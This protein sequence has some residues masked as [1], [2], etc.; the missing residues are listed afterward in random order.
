MNLVNN[1]KRGKNVPTRRLAAC[2]FLAGLMAASSVALTLAAPANAYDGHGGGGGHSGHFAGRAGGGHFAITAHFGG[3]G[4]GGGRFGGSSFRGGAY[5]GGRGSGGWGRG[6]WKAGYWGPGWYGYWPLALGFGYYYDAALA[7]PYVGL[8]AWDIGYG[9]G[10]TEADVRAQQN[11]MVQATSVPLDQPIDWNSANGDVSGSVTPVRDGRT[12]DGRLCREFQQH[13]TIDG[14]PQTAYGTA[15]Q[16][17]DG[18]WQI[19]KQS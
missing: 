1:A 6:Y 5:L 2:A 4:Y 14:K 8:S 19:I 7:S 18:A 15:C 16:Q 17:A 13:I 3:S 12:P 10:L 11:A 9:D